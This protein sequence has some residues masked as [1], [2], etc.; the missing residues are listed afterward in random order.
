[1][2]LAV[3]RFVVLR[4]LSVV[5]AECFQLCFFDFF[6]FRSRRGTCFHYQT[7]ARTQFARLFVLRRSARRVV[8]GADILG[9]PIG[10]LDGILDGFAVFDLSFWSSRTVPT[11]RRLAFPG[12]STPT[13]S[14]GHSFLL[15]VVVSTA[16]TTLVV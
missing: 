10:S 12:A 5:L 3:I 4:I 14:H 2:I 16:Y 15:F 7:V 13:E 6:G 8:G 1:M 11:S 9:L